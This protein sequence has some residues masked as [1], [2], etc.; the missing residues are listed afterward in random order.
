MVACISFVKLLLRKASPLRNLKNIITTSLFS[1]LYLAV[2]AQALDYKVAGFASIGAGYT[3]RPDAKFMDYGETLTGRSDTIFAL[4]INSQ[5]TE[6]TSFTSQVASEGYSSGSYSDFEPNINWLFLSHQFTPS[7]RGRLGRLRMPL[8][9]YSESLSVGYSYPW[10][11]P[12]VDVYRP[13]LTV[14]S[15]YEGVDINFIK[16]LKGKELEIVFLLGQLEG[17]TFDYST[18]IKVFAGTTLRLFEEDHS[19]RYG[20]FLGKMDSSEARFNQLGEAFTN[21]SSINPIFQDIAQSHRLEDGT[22]I[23]HSLGYEREYDDWTLN[24]EL[25][26]TLFPDRDFSTDILGSY[27]SL[28]KQIRNLRPYAVLGY[29]R[30]ELSEDLANQIRQSQAVVP[31]GVIPSLDGLRDTALSAYELFNNSGYS[32]TIGCRFELNPH[33]ALKLEIQYFDSS[34][35]LRGF[36]A[37]TQNDSITAS[38]MTVDFIF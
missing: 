18:E 24:T 21:F 35:A 7:I 25:N 29:S 31:T 15:N 9:M 13:E 6:A 20:F 26:A 11:R 17:N 8:Y 12:P 3:N 34:N 1:F 28:S 33:T 10:V 14:F 5:L 23:Y 36:T 22:V 27:I 4:Q 30:T 16:D 37:E 19:I 38:S 2:Q 32:G